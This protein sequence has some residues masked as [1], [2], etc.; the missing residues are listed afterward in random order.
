V[1]LNLC[2]TLKNVLIIRTIFN[3]NAIFHTFQKQNVV[4]A[5]FSF[6]T[7][8]THTFLF[9]PFTARMPIRIMIHGHIYD[10]TKLPGGNKRKLQDYSHSRRAPNEDSYI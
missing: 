6:P 8:F 3:Y 1:C 2:G 7:S 9:I 4:P 10:I 5:C